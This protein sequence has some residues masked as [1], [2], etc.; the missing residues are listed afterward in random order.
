MEQCRH[1]QTAKCYLDDLT[2]FIGCVIFNH[3]EDARL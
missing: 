2:L 1:C 3:Y